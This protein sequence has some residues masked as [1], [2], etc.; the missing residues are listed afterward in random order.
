MWVGG[1][2]HAPPAL[3]AGNT[4]YPL[5]RRLGGPQGRSGRLRKILPPTGIRSPDRPAR[6][7]SLYRLSYPSPLSK[8]SIVKKNPL[9]CNRP[10]L[11]KGQHELRHII[12]GT[13]AHLCV[14]ILSCILFTG[15]S[16]LL[17]ILSVYFCIVLVI[18]YKEG[19]GKFRSVTF[20]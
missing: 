18:I 17:S 1:Q 4:R 3:P 11:L 20:V 9:K 2:H 5:Y 16:R 13:V 14:V 19:A 7:E 15:R 12:E 6:S 8:H 10:V